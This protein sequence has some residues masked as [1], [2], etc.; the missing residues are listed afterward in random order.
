MSSETVRN[1]P[2]VEI[3]DS[4]YQLT[5]AEMQE[6]ININVTWEQ[7]ARAVVMDVELKVV[8]PTKKTRKVCFENV[9]SVISGGGSLAKTGGCSGAGKVSRWCRN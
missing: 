5:K 4:R 3:A 1:P 7:V 8:Y 2:A 9:L 6:D